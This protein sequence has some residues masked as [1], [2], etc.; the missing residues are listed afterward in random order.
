[1]KHLI[2]FFW[3]LTSN[4]FLLQE[5]HDHKTLVREHLLS[6]KDRKHVDY[7]LSEYIKPECDRRGL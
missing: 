5:L 7:L 4:R 1:M 6:D 3:K 2:K